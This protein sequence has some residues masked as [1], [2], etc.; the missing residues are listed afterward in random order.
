M[1]VDEFMDFVSNT[2]P[3]YS[4]NIYIGDFNLHISDATDTDSAI[5][6]D[7]TEAMGLYQHVA[8]STH[9]SGNL[10]DLILSDIGQDAT[11]MTVALGP[12]LTDHRPVISTLSLKKLK[13]TKGKI[14]IC[15]Y[16]KV[17]PEKWNEEFKTSNVPLSDKLNTLVTNF[18]NELS[19]IVETLAPEKTVNNNLRDKKPWYDNDIKQ[20]NRQ[21]RKLEKK[22]LRYKLD[23]C[24]TAYKKCRNRFYG[25]LNSKKNKH[26]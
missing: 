6:S 20:H 22:W 23:S 7:A 8:F 2:L 11:I 3:N 18:N 10:L 24:W 25:K 9:K 17:T 15:Q 26:S 16:S 14:K 19:R 12:F 1:F 5:F 13:A 21:M 4:N